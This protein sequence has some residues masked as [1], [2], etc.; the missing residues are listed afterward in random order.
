MAP[1]NYENGDVNESERRNSSISAQSFSSSRPDPSNIDIDD[2]YEEMNSALSQRRM[3]HKTSS[4]QSFYADHCIYLPAMLGWFFFSGLLSLYNKYVFGS[5]HMGFP[6]PLLMTSVHFLVQFLFSYGL[7]KRFPTALGGDQI[8]EMS[9]DKFL[10]IAIPCGLVTSL[11]VGFSNL[12]LV[13]ITITFYTMVKSSSPI[14]VVLSAYFFGI[15]KITLPLILTVLIISA[16]E[17]LTVMGEVEFDTIGF[18]LVLTAAVLSGM[19]WTVVQLK[20]QSLEPKLKS[21]IATMRILSPF[22]F[23]SMLFLSLVFE[24]PWTKFGPAN[25]SGIEYFSNPLDSLWTI[26]ISLLGATLA[27]FMIICE[28]YLIMKSSAV[29]L[30]IGGVLKELTTIMIGVSV[31]K[32][33]LNLTNSLGVA[34]VFSGVLLYKVSHHLEKKEKEYD[35]VDVNSNGSSQMFAEQLR[36]EEEQL[37]SDDEMNNASLSFDFDDDVVK[38]SGRRSKKSKN[39]S[40]STQSLVLNTDSEII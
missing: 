23:I 11:D 28:F 37:R 39:K 14:F 13:R 7:T 25:K 33:Q 6:C 21:T 32:D 22:M 9:W 3:E 2:D 8:D 24:E 26:G 16:G 19:R 34:V 18:C 31:M 15:E 17:F 10:G 35:S 20:L 1:A 29:V 5:T 27:I 38:D 36:Q 4:F 12:A 30:M 40:E